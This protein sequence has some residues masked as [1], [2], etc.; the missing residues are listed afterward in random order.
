ME[1]SRQDRDMGTEYRKMTMMKNIRE[2]DFIFY[3]WFAFCSKHTTNM[4]EDPT[5]IIKCN[6]YNHIR[7]RKCD[8]CKAECTGVEGY[9]RLI[10]IN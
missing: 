8:V 5:L 1:V 7:R 9:F 4:S 3:N 2:Y 10:C 6:V